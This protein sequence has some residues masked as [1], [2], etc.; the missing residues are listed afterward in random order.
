MNIQ[1]LLVLDS[2]CENALIDKHFHDHPTTWM[3][4]HQNL[5]NEITLTMKDEEM[6]IYIEQHK[7]EFS[8]IHLLLKCYLQDEK[9]I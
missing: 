1:T 9:N 7:N 2:Q 8:F 5:F 6:K 4:E 3:V